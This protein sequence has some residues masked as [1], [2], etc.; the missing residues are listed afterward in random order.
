MDYV[1]LL[2]RVH[3]TVTKREKVLYIALLT[4]ITIINYYT[5]SWKGLLYVTPFAAAPAAWYVVSRV[6]GLRIGKTIV[7]GALFLLTLYFT[8]P[9][10]FT[11]DIG[12]NISVGS[13]IVFFIVLLISHR[14]GREIE[15]QILMSEHTPVAKLKARS[16]KYAVLLTGL[17]IALSAVHLTGEVKNFL[18]AGSVTAII[19]GFALQ[20]TLGNMMAGLIAMTN[21]ALR[22]GDVVRVGNWVGKIEDVQLMSTTLVTPSNSHLIVPNEYFVTNPVEN[23]GRS[24]VVRITERVGISYDSPIERAVEVVRGILDADPDVLL[25]P[26]PVVGVDEF[27][28]SSVV[29]FFAYYTPVDSLVS[30]RARVLEAVKREFDR[31]GIVI[32]FPQLDVHLRE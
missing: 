32:P 28:D 12:W 3:S 7:Y 22:P 6:R 13:I 30:T 27:A 9:W 2:K 14:V 25:E 21:N 4:A 18:L 24:G 29:I 17:F 23:Y 16:V 1:F 10:A 15:E 19:L 31:R 5:Q 8:F 26:G 11:Y 20:R